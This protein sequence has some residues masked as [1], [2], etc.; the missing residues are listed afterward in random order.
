[1][2]TG[3]IVF[4]TVFLLQKGAKQGFLTAKYAKYAKTR[5]RKRTAGI[6]QIS[7]A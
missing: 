6:W 3:L 5:Q 1:M 4:T 2:T 7:G